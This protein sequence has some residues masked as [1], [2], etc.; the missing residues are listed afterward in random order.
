MWA[1]VVG[2]RPWSVLY[3]EV[4]TFQTTANTEGMVLEYL[5]MNFIGELAIAHWLVAELCEMKITR[6]ASVS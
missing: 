6:T 5:Y 2:F 1:A 3:E 4:L